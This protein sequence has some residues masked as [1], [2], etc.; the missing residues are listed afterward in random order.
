[1][2]IKKS[3]QGETVIHP[4]LARLRRA[5]SVQQPFEAFDPRTSSQTSQTNAP[6]PRTTRLRSQAPVKRASLLPLLLRSPP[7]GAAAP[8]ATRLL[9]MV[10]PFWFARTFSRPDQH[11]PPPNERKFEQAQKRGSSERGRLCDKGASLLGLGFV[12]GAP[13]PAQ[14]GKLLLWPTENCLSSEG[15]KFSGVSPKNMHQNV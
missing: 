10:S 9:T 7:S 8:K 15:N 6:P 4:L 5:D 14:L 3:R 12:D 11:Q 2:N 1:M 13:A